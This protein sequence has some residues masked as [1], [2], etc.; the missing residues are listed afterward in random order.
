MHSLFR[1]GHNLQWELGQAC[2]LVHFAFLSGCHVLEETIF[3]ISLSS[4]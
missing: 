4:L 1:G 3:I 2:I